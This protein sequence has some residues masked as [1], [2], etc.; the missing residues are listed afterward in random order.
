MAPRCPRAQVRFSCGVDRIAGNSRPCCG[1]KHMVLSFG[2]CGDE[3]PPAGDDKSPL[4]PMPKRWVSR[5]FRTCVPRIQAAG[6]RCWPV[7]RAISS[8]FLA[9]WAVDAQLMA[10]PS[11]R[12]GG[13]PGAR[14]PL[15][16]PADVA[17]R[18][19]WT[20]PGAGRS[21]ERWILERF[22]TRRSVRTGV[23]RPP[24]TVCRWHSTTDAGPVGFEVRWC[25][26]IHRLRDTASEWPIRVRVTTAN[27]GCVSTRILNVD[28]RRPMV[29]AVPARAPTGSS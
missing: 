14:N 17:D 2:G 9:E 7:F 1:T 22:R 18:K 13:A 19:L 8:P 16:A 20:H 26:T 12:R 24:A 25:G 11:R 15:P 3:P 5:T 6:S 27:A 28:R 23:V 29:K 21:H 4:G 10:P